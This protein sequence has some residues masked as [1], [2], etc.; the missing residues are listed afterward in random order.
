MTTLI[1]IVVAL[2][3]IWILIS[4]LFDNIGDFMYKIKDRIKGEKNKCQKE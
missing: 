3:I 4:P 1:T 2:I